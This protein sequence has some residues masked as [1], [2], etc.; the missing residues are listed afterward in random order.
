[1]FVALSLLSFN[2]GAVGLEDDEPDLGGDFIEEQTKKIEVRLPAYPLPA[3]LLKVE[4]D[5]AG[6]PYTYYIDTNSLKVLDNSIA[7]YTVV[8]E[9]ES[10]A[11][12]VM[13]EGIRCQTRE[14]RSYA[15]GTTNG[16]LSA[17][18]SSKWL[19]LKDA[20]Q[21]PYRFSFYQHYLCDGLQIPYV[22]AE[23]I[24]HIKY[25]ENFQSTGFLGD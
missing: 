9:S 4:V 13:F 12:N 16:K 1:M 24:N 3:N 8:I 10:G 5:N 14:S 20:S 19:S 17:F 21:L 18:S 2:V 6:S 23:V 25:P 11:R 15:Y 7:L 22:K